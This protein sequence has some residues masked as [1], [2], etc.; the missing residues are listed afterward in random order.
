M[1]EEPIREPLEQLPIPLFDGAVLAVRGHDGRIFLSLR[2]LCDVLGLRVHGQ[3]RRIQ[4]DPQLTLVS[5]R[6]VIQSQ[7]REI[8]CLLL[9]DVPL[10]LLSIQMNRVAEQVRTRVSYIRT[11]LVVSVQRAFGE[12]T[13]L[14]TLGEQPSSAIED[15]RE[16]DRI[17]TAFQ[18]LHQI[19][20]RQD[21]SA[22]V[23]RTIL[24]DLRE[25]RERLQRLE[26]QTDI[27]LS[28]EQRGTIFNLVQRWGE[29]RVSQTPNQ[30]RG[31]VI[32]RCWSEVNARFKVSTY[33]DLPAARYD[34]IL[35]FIKQNYTAL[36]GQD[37]DATQQE[38]LEL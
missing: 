34:E 36:T 26:Q 32:R 9:E 2:D 19:A 37:I 10:W 14:A 30:E 31:A 13:G 33:T 18:Q 17:D 16:L 1:S 21:R 8:D 25:L 3:R 22:I 24:N 23:V 20:E 28:P 27:R 6:L 29:V 11:Y 12:L 35:Q 7:F 15:L 38:R 5:F 4:S